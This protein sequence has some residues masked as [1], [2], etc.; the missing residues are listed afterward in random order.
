M[1]HRQGRNEGK[2]KEDK[3]HR[4]VSPT[5]DSLLFTSRFTLQ[6]S[7]ESLESN[8]SIQRKRRRPRILS[9]TTP[10]TD[11]PQ[12]PPPH[13]QNHVQK[14]FVQPHIPAGNVPH[15]AFTFPQVTPFLV[16]VF[17]KSGPYHPIEQ[18]Q[19][20]HTLPLSDEYGVYVWCVVAFGETNGSPNRTEER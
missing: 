1:W 10:D 7:P 13:H 6:S 16:R 11:P 19:E 2:L 17:V 18:F 9:P 15:H 8:G 4:G 14:G 12:C 5:L 20:A 3:T